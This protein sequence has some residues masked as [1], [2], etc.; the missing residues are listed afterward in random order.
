MKKCLLLVAIL[1]FIDSA[2]AQQG[3]YEKGFKSKN[4]FDE[5]YHSFIE[6][7]ATSVTDGEHN[8]VISLRKDT[9]CIC[10]EGKISTK[11]G[12]IIPPLMV[13][14]EDGTYEQSKK[15]LLPKL[16]KGEGVPSHLF[17]VSN[18]MSQTF[19]TN[20]AYIA[21]IFFVDFLKRKV[22]SPAIAPSPNDI[23][24]V[25]PGG[26]NEKE[27]ELIKKTYEG[28]QF[29]NGKTKI[30]TTSYAQLN[31]F[32]SMLK[33]KK[34]YN[35]FIKGYTDNVGS[36]ESNLLLSKG[37]AESVKNYLIKQGLDEQNITAE[38]FGIENPIADNKTPEGR[39]QNR[40][41]EFTVLQ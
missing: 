40:R 39:A 19:M 33:E 10:V 4:C 31:L 23:S 9:S 24:G 14:R 35:L 3:M 27:K 2:Y 13:K 16:L 6:R 32:A 17:Y 20:D 22:V 36:P 8:I 41:V 11:H 30:L 34:D 1:I 15:K 18:G 5:Y 21:N 37:R 7:G 38:G 26:L 29:Q 28:L 25:Q 12:E